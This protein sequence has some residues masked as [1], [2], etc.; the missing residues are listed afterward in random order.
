MTGLAR[1]LF[2]VV[3]AEL[4]AVPVEECVMALRSPAMNE[5]RVK[6]VKSAR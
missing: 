1:S 5:E 2:A 3:E 4:P 6:T